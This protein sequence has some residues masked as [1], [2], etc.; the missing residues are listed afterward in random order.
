MLVNRKMNYYSMLKMAKSM[1]I[2]LEKACRSRFI[3]V[4]NLVEGLIE[5]ISMMENYLDSEII[6]LM[7]LSGSLNSDW[8]ILDNLYAKVGLSRLEAKPTTFTLTLK[9]L[10]YSLIESGTILLQNIETQDYFLNS[11]DFIISSDGIVKDVPFESLVTDR[12]DLSETTTLKLV[13]A[14][15]MVES[16]DFTTIQDI[17]LGRA[18]ESDDEYRLRFHKFLSSKDMPKEN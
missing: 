17:K 3:D 15:A 18:C 4:E 1:L 7:Q 12:I 14:P 10:Q 8:N 5:I 16:I 2:K 9:G 6:N 13:E 11:T